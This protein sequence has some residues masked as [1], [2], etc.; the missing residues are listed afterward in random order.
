MPDSA[1]SFKDVSGVGGYG[2]DKTYARCRALCCQVLDSN[3]SRVSQ[4]FGKIIG[5]LLYSLI[6]IVLC[7]IS[8]KVA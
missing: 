4:N 5:K 2:P 1:V 6:C 8:N 3:K 7:E